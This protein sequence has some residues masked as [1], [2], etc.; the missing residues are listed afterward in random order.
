[1]SNT[2]AS[3]FSIEVRSRFGVLPNF[4]CTAATAPG[5][6]EELWGFAK[7]AY[8]DNPL[9]SLFKER[10]FV[11]LSRFCEVR[12]C[13]VRH[14][15][16]LVGQGHPAGDSTTKPQSVEEAIALLQKPVPRAKRLERSLDL[17]EHA[18]RQET[19]PHE[20]TEL[21]EALFDVLT[22]LF[23]H[24]L[25][26]ERAR[27]AVMRTFGEPTFEILIAFLAFVRTAH[28]WTENHP[29]LE[30]EADMVGLIK[31]HPALGHLLLDKADADWAQSSTELRRALDELRTASGALRSTEERFRALVVATSDILYR[32][33]ADWS[34]MISL[35]GR[36]VLANT[37][38]PD[39]DWRLRYIP[40]DEQPRLSAAIQRA[41][42]QKTMF[43]LEH[44]VLR[45]DGTIGWVLSRAAPILD[46]DNQVVEW[47]GAA[48]DLTAHKGAEE[49]LRRADRRKDEFLATLAHELR[50]PL[51][52]LRNGL[53]IARRSSSATA[54]L[55][56]TVEMMDR[57]V[58]MLVHLV[59]DL[60]D[61]SRITSGKIELRRETVSLQ[62]AL[63]SS[64]DTARAAMSAHGHGSVLRVGAEDLFID[65]DFDRLTQ[66]FANLLSNAIKYTEDAGTIEVHCHREGAEAVVH[67]IDTGIGI[68]RERLADIFDMFSQVRSHAGRA[69]GGLG[70][71]LALVQQLVTMH[72]GTVQA[73]SRG[74]NQGSTFTVRL[75]LSL[76][77]AAHSQ[78]VAVAVN[79]Q[80]Q[81]RRILIADDNEDAASSLATLL[82]QLGH[83]VITARDGLDAIARATV[84]RPE[85][86]F[87]DLGMPKMDGIEA[88]RRLRTLPNG[89]DTTLIALTGWGQ[90]NDFQR[91]RAAGFDHHFLKPVDLRAIESLLS[92]PV[93]SAA[94]R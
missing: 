58:N 23:I 66:V 5:L 65:G 50:N 29:T 60:L 2:A 32:V 10:L 24:P 35:D 4:F 67:I 40:I 54:E 18:S 14:V 22:I 73:T 81:G 61:V 20:D 26:N 6:I 74:L 86:V 84:F 79:P 16:F 87:L 53:E 34:Q 37:S 56:P 31:D 3:A 17:V 42:S 62:K 55:G 33:N 21:E 72:G 93:N 83:A 82:G 12:Y 90:E 28:Y 27:N 46:D 7:S 59:D 94:S 63:A 48:I 71:G 69:D 91:T 80:L 13:I 25:G 76:D 41:I 1:M 89:R 88:A 70:I 64:L 92:T 11:H 38:S 8:L 77:T 45:Q 68:P 19:V 36:G 51:A 85:I 44:R 30:Y 43:E 39:H 47:L 52:P 78:P 9:P 49:A 57:Q 75:P 15:G